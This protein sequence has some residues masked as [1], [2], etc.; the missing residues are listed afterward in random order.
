MRYC[1][2]RALGMTHH[3]RVLIDDWVK[4]WREL[5]AH[6]IPEPGLKHWPHLPSPSP[7]LNTPS[8]SEMHESYS[9]SARGVDKNGVL[10]FSQ[11]LLGEMLNSTA[12]IFPPSSSSLLLLQPILR[13]S[14]AGISVP[15]WEKRRLWS[16][17]AGVHW[18]A[19]PPRQARS[20]Q[21][22][23]TVC[24]SLSGKTPAAHSIVKQQERTNE[25]PW[26]KKLRIFQHWRS[27]RD[28]MPIKPSSQQQVS[29]I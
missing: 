3:G 27:K 14:N 9:T 2:K 11:A 20:P 8:L 10:L 1:I 16:F 25:S 15:L 17:P 13:S 18:G 6:T 21:L 12:N 24:C 28:R 26:I 22:S 19:T 29:Y 7:E 5:V 4:P 23:Q